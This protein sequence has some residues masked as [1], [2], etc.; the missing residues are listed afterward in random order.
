MPEIKPSG[1]MTAE[2]KQQVARAVIGACRRNGASDADIGVILTL[3]FFE[4]LDYIVAAY[5]KPPEILLDPMIF[6][7]Q[8][9][10][11]KQS[12]NNNQIELN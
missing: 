8:L 1:D 6:A 11:G 4:H 5:Q 10:K 3:A 2:L 9:R 7:C 12:H